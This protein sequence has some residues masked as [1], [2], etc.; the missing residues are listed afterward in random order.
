[1]EGARTE[2][3]V[4]VCEGVR[5]LVPQAAR[6]RQLRGGCP[7]E[8]AARHAE[9]CQHLRRHTQAVGCMPSHPLCRHKLL[10]A[11]Q[12]EGHGHLFKGPQ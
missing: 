7:P 9:V 8:V 6:Q 4:Q 11:V 12:G 1:M 3:V 5:A 2:G 10:I